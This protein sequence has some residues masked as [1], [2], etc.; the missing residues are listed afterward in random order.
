MHLSVDCHS[1]P[2]THGFLCLRGKCIC[3]YSH[4]C[5]PLWRLL[6]AR[7][8]AYFATLPVAVTIYQ[9]SLA[10]IGIPSSEEW[11]SQV[12]LALLYLFNSFTTLWWVGPLRSH[13]QSRSL[14]RSICWPWN[15]LGMACMDSIKPL[16]L[17]ILHSVGTCPSAALSVYWKKCWV[18]IWLRAVTCLN[19]G[20][21]L[22]SLLCRAGL[23]MIL[24][25]MMF[26]RFSEACSV[27]QLTRIS[28]NCRKS[29]PAFCSCVCN[30]LH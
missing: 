14:K 2:D 1:L 6:N 24:Q 25:A 30:C 8:I 5:I 12:T 23:A 13:S 11:L 28:I 19:I 3:K 29:H 4:Q 16:V 26:N 20:A 17:D 22:G 18:L 9:C 7:I 21:Y 15:R 27:K 10:N